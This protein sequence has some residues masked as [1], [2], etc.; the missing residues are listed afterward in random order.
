M[1]DDGRSSRQLR[2][3]ALHPH[4]RY[5]VRDNRSASTA[6]A[7]RMSKLSPDKYGTEGMK[8]VRVC[9]VSVCER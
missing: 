7:L 1:D 6:Q 5:N 2:A 8:S 9:G 4:R 3:P